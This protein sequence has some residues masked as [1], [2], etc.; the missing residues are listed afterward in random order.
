MAL[1]EVNLFI[2]SFHLLLV[3]KPTLCMS[4]VC[5]RVLQQVA[6]LQR[7]NTFLFLRAY[8]SFV[9]VNLP[10]STLEGSTC[11]TA[12]PAQGVSSLEHQSYVFQHWTALPAILLNS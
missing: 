11:P 1:C 7:D 9:S 2:L 10:V 6:I 12:N 8:P 5:V 3:R 4:F